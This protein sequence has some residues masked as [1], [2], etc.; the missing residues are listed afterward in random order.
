MVDPKCPRPFDKVVWKAHSNSMQFP[1]WKEKLV[2]TNGQFVGFLLV[3]FKLGR[4]VGTSARFF[5]M[6][7]TEHVW[8]QILLYQAFCLNVH[9]RHCI[10]SCSKYLVQ[11]I[12][13]ST[14][15]LALLTWLRCAWRSDSSNRRGMTSWVLSFSAP[16]WW[17]MRWCLHL[18]KN[19]RYLE[20]DETGLEQSWTI[21]L[22]ADR[23]LGCKLCAS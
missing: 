16:T 19:Y 3:T 8:I 1:R 14:S 4:E 22:F 2:P 15:M 17:S 18:P 12:I 13:Y 10:V 7:N 21:Q 23:L 20:R 6:M 11:R 5:C 9:M